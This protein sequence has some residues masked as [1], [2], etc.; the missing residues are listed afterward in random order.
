MLQSQN[1]NEAFHRQS[2]DCEVAAVSVAFCS[3]KVATIHA[4]FA[5]RKATMCA[6][7]FCLAILLCGF[8][9]TATAQ[10]DKAQDAKAPDN[11]KKTILLKDAGV[12]QKADEAPKMP[13]VRPALQIRREIN[14]PNQAVDF[15]K[16]LVNAELSFVKRVCDP[17]DEQMTA[18]VAA[19]KEA[20]EALASIVQDQRQPQA[21]DPFGRRQEMFIGPN[22]QRMSVNPFKRVREDV[23][24]LLQPLVSAEQYSRYTAEA[25]ARDEFERD[26]V[27][28]TLLEML[29]TKLVLSPDQQTQLR[30]KLGADDTLMD[31]HSLAIYRS[32]AQYL[33][34]LPETLIV[35]ILTASQKQVW[36][37]LNRVNIQQSIVQGNP[38]GFAEEWLK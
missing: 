19:A 31:L 34:Q 3:A 6:T 25:K 7:L 35:P 17:T 22:N 38:T 11:N 23:A 24:K 5:E 1:Q 16:P 13:G 21:V 37:S 4:T 2:D 32:N 27:V 28:E 14:N 15:L 18:I 30:E 8:Y 29:D 12:I 9:N 20:N 36:N 10:D 33:P 26:A